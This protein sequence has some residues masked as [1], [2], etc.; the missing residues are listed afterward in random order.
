[1]KYRIRDNETKKY[2]SKPVG[3]LQADEWCS[4]LNLTRPGRY[5]VVCIDVA[6]QEISAEYR[7]MTENEIRAIGMLP[8]V[9]FASGVP[10]KSFANVLL[11][12][13]SDKEPEITD[14]QAAYLWWIVYHYR[15]QIGDQRIVQLAEA[16]KVY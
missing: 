8:K 11:A 14:R 12:Q 2:V 6:K 15:R 7:A 4:K 5:T 9:T 1:V 3:S 13:A 10:H 16:N